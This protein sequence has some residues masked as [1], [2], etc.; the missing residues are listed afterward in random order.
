MGFSISWIAVKDTNIDSLSEQLNLRVT[1]QTEEFP[2]SD[3]S[4]A[5]LSNGWCHIQFNDFDSPYT[6]ED[7]LSILS[8]HH[9]LIVCQIEE[10]VMY[11]K[12]SFWSS[13][14]LKWSCS[15]DAQEDLYNL[16]ES[17]ELPENYKEIKNN[18]TQEQKDSDDDV[19][20]IFDIPLVLA[21]SICGIKHDELPEEDTLYKDLES[22]VAITKS[23]NTKAW[24]KFWK[25]A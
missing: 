3:I 1:D 24:W 22:P 10:H 25:S 7:K 20:C 19:D 18:H 5:N 16:S 14:T 17:G 9:D 23:N 15:H 13:G 8:E 21:S 11:S 2:E 4:G 12:S 6:Q